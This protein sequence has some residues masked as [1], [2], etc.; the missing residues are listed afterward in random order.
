MKRT[1]WI[2]VAI[3]AGLASMLVVSSAAGQREEGRHSGGIF[4]YKVTND[5]GIL[6]AEAYERLGGV[7]TVG[8]PVSYRF[9]AWWGFTAQVMQGAVFESAGP[10]PL[11]VRLA[12]IFEILKE[13][14]L[15]DWLLQ[16]KGI[17]RPIKDD[18][19]GGDWKKARNIRLSWLTNEKIKARFLANPNP[20]KIADWNESHAIRLY[21][22]PMSYPERHGPFISQRFQRVAFQ[23]W[24][25]EVEGM[26]APGTV[27]RVLGGDL[28]KEAGLV[29]ARALAPEE[30]AKP[31]PYPDLFP[32]PPTTAEYVYSWGEHAPTV[33]YGD[34]WGYH[35]IRTFGHYS[36]RF[37]TQGP[38]LN[39]Y[40]PEGF[41]G[42]KLT[43]RQFGFVCKEDETHCRPDY[44][45][46]VC[47]EYVTHCGPD[48][49]ILYRSLIGAIEPGRVYYLPPMTPK[50]VV[51]SYGFG[52]YDAELVAGGRDYEE[53][54]WE[55]ESPGVYFVYL[56]R[57]W[58][59]V[60]GFR[61]DGPGEERPPNLPPLITYTVSV[62]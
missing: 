1:T 36:R 19:S 60:S 16:T 23:L 53:I 38:F 31:E 32:D 26:P 15:D 6:F 56:A 18:G 28:F 39:L 50:R 54:V 45:G 35:W 34:Y 52:R 57:K 2:A 46:F 24:V 7:D 17:P 5:D 55:I 33:K 20:E 8:Y 30:H 62:E 13:R 44:F 12:N 61:Y 3:L 4:D 9:F 41:V 42:R 37:G 58:S 48:Y 47:K 11:R 49:M 59:W 14:G 10:R 43:I 27:V 25:E 29:P 51:N 22:L 21:G 40:F